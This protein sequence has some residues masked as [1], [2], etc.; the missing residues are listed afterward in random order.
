VLEHL[1]A[2][3]SGRIPARRNISIATISPVKPKVTSS[4]M[5]AVILREAC[6]QMAREGLALFGGDDTRLNAPIEEGI[7]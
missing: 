1:G 6:H 4:T 7:V 3:A 5:N 2:I